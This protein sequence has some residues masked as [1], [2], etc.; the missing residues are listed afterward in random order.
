MAMGREPYCKVYVA[1]GDGVFLYDWSRNAL[2]EISKDDIRGSIGK[3][4]F[5]AKA[6]H[7][8]IFVID[9]A[10]VEGFGARGAEWGYAAVGAMT[11]NV[12]LAAEGLGIGVRYIA[13]LSP[14]VA[15]EALKLAA[16][17]VPACIMPIGKR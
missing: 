8:L 5:V 3:Q 10:A 13:S 2:K 11:Q 12:Y 1:G 15:R 14:D 4:P 7:V 16:K 6:S 9:G 17:D